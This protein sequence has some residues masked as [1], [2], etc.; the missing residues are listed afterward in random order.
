MLKIKD[1]SKFHMYITI[2]KLEFFKYFFT[3]IQK[4]YIKLNETDKK[5]ML[6]KVFFFYINAVIFIYLLLSTT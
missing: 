3:F 4:G 5:T 6:T 2:Q 1:F